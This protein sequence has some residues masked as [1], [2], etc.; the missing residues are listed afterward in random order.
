MTPTMAA[1]RNVDAPDASR[2]AAL[3]A[4]P[5]IVARNIG[6][7][8][9]DLCVLER[10]NISVATGE[11]VT[12]LGPSGCGK[13]TL[14]R[15]LA[16]LLKPSEGRVHVHGAP[17]D[18]GG[19]EDG[20]L[21]L[22]FQKPLLLPWRDTLQNV[23]LP[24]ELERSGN[25]VTEIDRNQARRMLDLV[26]L[27]GFEKSYP[28]QLSGGMQQRVAIAR[29]LMSNPGILLMDEPF[30]A[31]DEIT[32]EVMNEELLRIWHSAQTR[33][34]TIVMVT[35]SLHEAVQMSDRIFV[36]APRPARVVEVVTVPVRRPR[37]PEDP[38][39]TRVT[40]H[41]RKLVRSITC[42]A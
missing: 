19:S 2:A 31:L 42:D 41:V 37:S 38:E 17:L 13:S 23:L 1:L 32:R 22:V 16:G 24:K 30:G 7:R 18:E 4:P 36:L 26:R 21:G 10:M 3:D 15:V 35:H 27:A 25:T 40:A 12:L 29:A 8:F 33:L 6:V 14:L 5:C 39:L 11:F 20:R 34:S 28:A 9:G